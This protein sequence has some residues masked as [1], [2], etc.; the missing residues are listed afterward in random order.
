[1]GLRLGIN[2]FRDSSTGPCF[3]LSPGSSSGLTLSLSAGTSSGPTTRL[4]SPFLTAII[5]TASESPF[6]NATMLKNSLTHLDRCPRLTN[7]IPSLQFPDSTKQLPH[8]LL[9]QPPSF[10]IFPDISATNRQHKPPPYRPL[11][12]SRV[13]LSNSGTELETDSK[14]HKIAESSTT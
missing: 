11:S 2:V 7:G 5:S 13:L 6:C 1:M 14:E 10:R 8:I 3:S 9:L 12:P 4:Q